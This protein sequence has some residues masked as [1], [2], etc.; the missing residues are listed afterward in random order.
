MEQLRIVIETER[1]SEYQNE[2][3]EWEIAIFNPRIL[4]LFFELCI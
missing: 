3:D 1:A 4:K 2:L